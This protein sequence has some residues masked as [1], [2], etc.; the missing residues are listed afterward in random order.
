M[1]TAILI[2][3]M[4]VGLAGAA[5]VPTVS[6]CALGGPIP[7]VTLVLGDV[8]VGDGQTERYN[9]GT[10]VFHGN[11]TVQSGGLV[12]M[13]LSDV[14]F[15]GAQPLRVEAGGTI[16]IDGSSLSGS[17]GDVTAV[18]QLDAGA[19]VQV[20]GSNFTY[21]TLSL[22][23]NDALVEGNYFQLGAPAVR[24]TDFSGT[25]RENTFQANLV[26]LNAT[27]GAPTLED[28][29]FH[30]DTL[31][32]QLHAV[33]CVLR[34]LALLDVHDGVLLTWSRC[35]MTNMQLND[36]SL[37]PTRGLDIRDGVGPIEVAH[38]SISR[39]GTGI[40]YCNADVNMHD[41]SFAGNGQDVSSC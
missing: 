23:S 25:F 17:A 27:G 37:P 7:C 2:S 5:P 22:A 18:L 30:G 35:T 28:L 33:D 4:L 8:I 29:T 41:N 32:L 11:V 10:Y 15:S 13:I 36:Q 12:E 40:H 6:T 38:N 14:S 20:V 1:R 9:N 21:L 24:L 3:V 39:F 34:H 31:A 26:G 16:V 19:N